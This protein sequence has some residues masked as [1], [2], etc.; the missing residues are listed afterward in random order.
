MPSMNNDIEFSG[1]THSLLLKSGPTST[2]HQVRKS[3]SASLQAS[4][5]AVKTKRFTKLDLTKLERPRMVNTR[6]F[7]D[8]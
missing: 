2:D 1:P 5:Q 8:D 4:P 6:R 3:M 7:A